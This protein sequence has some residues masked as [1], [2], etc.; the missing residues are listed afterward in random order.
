M[1]LKDRIRA[2]FKP[3]PPGTPTLDQVLQPMSRAEINA[4]YD[5]GKAKMDAALATNPRRQAKVAA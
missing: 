3:A 1:N 2:A 5:A 4:R